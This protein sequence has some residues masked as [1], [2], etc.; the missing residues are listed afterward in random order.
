MSAETIIQVAT[1]LGLPAALLVAGGVYVAKVLLPRIFEQ[2]DS[3]VKAAAAEHER[4]RAQ[5]QAA[6]DRIL[7]HSEQ[8]GERHERIMVRWAEVLQESPVGRAL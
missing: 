1:Q 5:F 3:A 7:Q 8:Q 2:F 4:D 6:L